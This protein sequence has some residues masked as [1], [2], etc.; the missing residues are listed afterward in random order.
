VVVVDEWGGRVTLTADPVP[1]DGERH[2]ARLAAADGQSLGDGQWE[3]V[4][5]DFAMSVGTSL[6]Y[7][8]VGFITLDAHLEAQIVGG[9]ALPGEW[10]AVP[11]PRSNAV[12]PSTTTLNADTVSSAFAFSPFELAWTSGRLR[13]LA[14]APSEVLP[15]TLSATA[16]SELG[17]EPGDRFTVSLGAGELPVE[18]VRIAP[19]V[20]SHP[21]GAVVL[22]DAEALSRAALAA[23][24]TRPLTT[25]WWSSS[26]TPI[27]MASLADAGLADASTR[28]ERADA[29]RNGPLRV[30]LPVALAILLV[31]CLALALIG[32]AAHSSAEARARSLGS[33]RLR[34]LGVP[35]RAVWL[36]AVLQHVTL[37]TGAVILGAALGISVGWVLAPLLVVAS[38]GGVAIPQ[39]QFAMAPAV[40]AATVAAILVATIAVGLPATRAL[41]A[42]SAAVGL[43][44]GEPL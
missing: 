20:P 10:L 33:A 7:E 18:V 16:A 28:W 15:V 26:D 5:M 42:R 14:F 23:G 39:A 9:S 12:V 38:D 22:A 19:Y 24:D 1:F 44:M 36:S 11:T 37:T 3:V 43:R 21:R 40:V 4:A 6:D 25:G 8:Q 41:V 35:R 27:A 30:G 2:L 34:G 32:T 29:F 31:A 13:L 17:L